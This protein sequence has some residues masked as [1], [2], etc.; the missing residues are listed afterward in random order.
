MLVEDLDEEPARG[1]EVE[2]PGPV[3]FPGRVGIKPIGFQ[4]L[5]E[6]IHLLAAVLIE[7]NVKRARVLDVGGLVEIAQRQNE[8]RLVD[9]DGDGPWASIRHAPKA[10]V[11][12]EEFSGLRDVGD[13]QVEVI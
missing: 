5:V 13:R 7:A 6:P 10:E 9:E 11:G 12:L 8:A 1:A 4:T 2:G 3:K